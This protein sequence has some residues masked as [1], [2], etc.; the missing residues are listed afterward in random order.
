MSFTRVSSE[1]QHSVSAFGLLQQ[2]TSVC[3]LIGVNCKG[4]LE[5]LTTLWSQVPNHTHPHQGR[6]RSVHLILS[7]DGIVT[8]WCQ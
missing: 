1:G 3:S 6:Q 5:Q 4:N 7:V 2:V 8:L